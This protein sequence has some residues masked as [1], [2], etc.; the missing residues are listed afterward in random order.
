MVLGNNGQYLSAAAEANVADS[1]TEVYVGNRVRG[2]R[3]QDKAYYLSAYGC[4]IG[5]SLLQG[6]MGLSTAKEAILPVEGKKPFLFYNATAGSLVVGCGVMQN[7]NQN[8]DFKLFPI[9][10]PK[11][12]DVT[13]KQG[14]IISQQIAN[15][16][17]ANPKSRNNFM[18]PYKMLTVIPAQQTLVFLP[19][20]KKDKPL[21]SFVIVAKSLQALDQKLSL[22]DL[23]NSG[24]LVLSSHT[25]SQE[26]S[27]S[28]DPKSPHLLQ[29]AKCLRNQAHINYY[30]PELRV[31]QPLGQ[32]EE[33]KEAA[34]VEDLLGL[35]AIGNFN[36]VAMP[37]RRASAG[38]LL[39]EAEKVTRRASLDFERELQ[40]ADLEL[41]LKLKKRLLA[42]E[43][44]KNR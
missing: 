21:S 5:V 14:D 10:V 29:H 12:D 15:Y 4:K 22:Q 9:Y 11:Q 30:Q 17:L 41:Q 20:Q 1:E 27:I 43:Q 40:G 13:I 31:Q 2:A 24:V 3:A 19:V 38:N 8:S 7:D 36:E 34:E 33:G 18:V 16:M 44:A 28:E 42:I 26:G 25:L 6:M 35:S 32:E 39:P 37:P 23:R